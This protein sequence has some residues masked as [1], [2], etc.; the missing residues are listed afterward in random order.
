MSRL[1]TRSFLGGILLLTSACVSIQES[2]GLCVVG[3]CAGVSNWQRKRLP[4]RSWDE[5]RGHCERR[6]TEESEKPP[7][8]EV[9]DHWRPVAIATLGRADFMAISSEKARELTGQ[10]F[11]G[12]AF[13]VLSRGL[14]G[15]ALQVRLDSA[16]CL[17]VASM[18]GSCFDMPPQAPKYAPV[19]IQLRAPPRDLELF[20]YQDCI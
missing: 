1:R 11:P 16:G 6:S 15:R 12:D 5:S 4:K 17:E 7:F 2:A 14:K 18:N 10:E 8:G 9:L 20:V 3:S 13:L 19:V